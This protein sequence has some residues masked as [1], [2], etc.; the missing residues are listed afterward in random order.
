MEHRKDQGF[1]IAAILPVFLLLFAVACAGWYIAKTNQLRHQHQAAS[2]SVDPYAGW[3]TY[4][5]PDGTF[6][7]RLPA[8]WGTTNDPGLCAA[9]ELKNVLCLTFYKSYKSV[10][11]TLAEAKTVVPYAGAGAV[12][13]D[14]CGPTGK[15]GTVKPVDEDNVSYVYA[16]DSQSVCQQYEFW[17]GYDEL[18]IRHLDYN[19]LIKDDAAHTETVSPQTFSQIARSVKFSSPSP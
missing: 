5:A 10:P 9:S 12:H 16:I 2:V 7:L 15:I 6:S 8:G 3:Q 13:S 1:S 18:S 14:A 17:K 19:H 4:R 11:I